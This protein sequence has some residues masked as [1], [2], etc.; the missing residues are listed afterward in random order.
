MPRYNKLEDFESG[1]SQ[2]SPFFEALGFSTTI[3]E[4][5]RDKEGTYY[6]AGFTQPPRSVEFTHLY[7]LGSILYSI[8][9]FSI[10]HTYY[11]KALGATSLY[12][13]YED[14]S[15]SGYAAWLHDL[16][17]LLSPFFT[18]PEQDFIAIASRYM[19][20]QREQFALDTTAQ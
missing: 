14:N 4:P 18:G 11:M 12:P 8:R 9:A 13:S 15:I 1:L 3:A 16:Q 6:S 5:F 2:I 10:E 19:L 7:S 17:T 20:E